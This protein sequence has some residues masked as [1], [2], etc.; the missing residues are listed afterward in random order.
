MAP[1][2]MVQIGPSLP[3]PQPGTPPSSPNPSSSEHVV[4]LSNAQQLIDMVKAIVAMEIA[5]TPAAKCTCFDTPPESTNFQS[6]TPPLT[7]KDLEQLF[8][9]LL[10]VKSADASPEVANPPDAP[11]TTQT[12][13]VVAE[14]TK[15]EYKTVNEVYAVP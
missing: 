14:A 6:P 7:V 3:H 2:E 8:L 11:G 12:G 13:E 4:T 5:S 1:I 9:R 10:E 15:L